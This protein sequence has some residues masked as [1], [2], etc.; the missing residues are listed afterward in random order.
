MSSFE[1]MEPKFVLFENENDLKDL[2]SPLTPFRKR[3]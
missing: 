2:T 1:K 3:G